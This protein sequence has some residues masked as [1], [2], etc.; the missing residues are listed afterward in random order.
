M[1]QSDSIL[2]NALGVRD[3]SS[4]LSPSGATTFQL[5]PRKG[6]FRSKLHLYPRIPRTSEA[7]S[8]GKIFHLYMLYG[9]GDFQVVQDEITKKIDSLNRI[10]AEEGDLSGEVQKSVDETIRS[11]PLA[12]AMA[13]VYWRRFSDPPTMRV[14]GREL[15]WNYKPDWMENLGSS[16][17]EITGVIDRLVLYPPDRC[18]VQDYKTTSFDPNQITRSYHYS[19]ACRVYRLIAT[20]WLKD[21]GMEEVKVEGFQLNII[22]KPTIRYCKKDKDWEAYVK[23]CEVWYDVQE[24]EPCV[25]ETMIYLEDSDANL[26]HSLRPILETLSLPDPF[27]EGIDEKSIEKLETLYPRRAQHCIDWYG[28][29]CDYLDLC[30]SNPRLWPET[31]Q[32][33]FVQELKHPM[34]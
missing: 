13:R 21:K 29:P 6:Y 8:V 32:R 3:V 9:K 26:S 19:N 15:S 20:Q 27:L 10:I 7:L 28:R 33:H 11:A 14:L 18:Y 34:L 2:L 16:G 5:C 24:V 17:L 30:T 23:R 22:R 25:Q 4:P 1:T 12:R 31:I